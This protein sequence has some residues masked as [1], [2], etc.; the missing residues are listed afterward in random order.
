M[1]TGTSATS[2]WVFHLC[3]PVNTGWPGG[4][5]RHKVLLPP[6]HTRWMY[7]CC[8]V[9]HLSGNCLSPLAWLFH[10]SLFLGSK[11]TQ[12]LGKLRPWSHFTPSPTPIPPVG[13]DP[14]SCIRRQFVTAALPL[15]SDRA[16]WSTLSDWV[17]FLA[18][19]HFLWKSPPSSSPSLCL[20]VS[21]SFFFPLVFCRLLLQGWLLFRAQLMDSSHL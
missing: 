21:L 13:C 6:G 7:C 18:C 10:D 11:W 1:R 4:I 12:V 17:I 19:W 5:C 14:A 9:T 2:A 15:V 3:C 20:F 8:N 16:G